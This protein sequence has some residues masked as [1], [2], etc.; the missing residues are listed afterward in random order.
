MTAR[1]GINVTGGEITVGSA[2][3]VGQGGG[4]VTVTTFVGSLTG[5]ASSLSGVSSSFSLTTIISLILLQFQPT[6]TS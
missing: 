6:I 1:L 3:S 2:F 5:S 4:V